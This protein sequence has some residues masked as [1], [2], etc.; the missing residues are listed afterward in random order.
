[1][2]EVVAAAEVVIK[3]STGHAAWKWLAAACGAVLGFLAPTEAQ[4]QAVIG[5]AGLII[6]DM[7]TGI[8]ASRMKGGAITSARL[9]RTLGKLLAYGSVLAVI[10]VVCRTVEGLDATHAA[11]FTAAAALG[12]LTEALSI[13]E[14]AQAL[15]VKLPPWVTNVLRSRHN[16]AEGPSPADETG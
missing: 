12:I 13:I 2:K 7:V 1:M 6:L 11:L 15:G 14:N 8:A 9:S 5:L 10:A 4:Q 3:A 16:E